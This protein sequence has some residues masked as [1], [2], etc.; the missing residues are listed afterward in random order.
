MDLT[1]RVLTLQDF[2]LYYVLVFDLQSITGDFESRFGL[3][4]RA[5]R[6][7]RDH[8]SISDY[9]LVVER[10]RGRLNVAADLRESATAHL[11]F[12]GWP[13]VSYLGIT[14]EFCV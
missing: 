4:V 2:C 8:Q 14:P 5:R 3:M 7:Q 10:L 12:D 13:E 11:K 1:L 6:E 9:R